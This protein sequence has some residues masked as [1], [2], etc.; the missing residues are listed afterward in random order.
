MRRLIILT[1]LLAL[2]SI[3]GAQEFKFGLSY[4][5]IYAPQW[6]KIIQTYNFSRPFNSEMQPLLT[7][8]INASGSYIFNAE[9]KLKQGLNFSYSYFRSA[10]EN[11]N[12][13]NNL[14]LHFISLGYIFHYDNAEKLKGI[15]TDFIV[16]AISSGLFRNV[17]GE[18]FEYSETTSK[19]VGIGGELSFKLGYSMKLKDR[20][21]LSPFI[22][23]AYTPFFYSPNTETVI[24]QTKGLAGKS[25]T[26]ILNAQIGLAI[27]INKKD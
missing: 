15:Y 20:S 25:W 11:E 7:H 8:G 1:S 26:G 19:A 10:A 17:N 16:S 2:S 13:N 4:N 12:L 24:N 5:Y 18:P 27:H 14:N 3:T 6:D 21:K 9:K 22:Q 23:I